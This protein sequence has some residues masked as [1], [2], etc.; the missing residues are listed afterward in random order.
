MNE[1]GWVRTVPPA[2]PP[3]LCKGGGGCTCGGWCVSQGGERGA[4]WAERPACEW[5]RGGGC[6][7]CL[8]PS[9]HVMGV[10]GVQVGLGAAWVEG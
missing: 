6:S 2:L 1:R 5:E 3:D 10:E 7:V 8:A 4:A 9:M